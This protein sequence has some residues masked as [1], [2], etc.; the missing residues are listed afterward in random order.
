MQ[1]R[2]ATET[3]DD[4]R[5]HAQHAPE[6]NSPEVS[7]V[8]R[9]LSID[10]VIVAMGIHFLANVVLMVLVIVTAFQSLGTPTYLQVLLTILNPIVWL[11]DPL[12]PDSILGGALCL[13]CFVS[14][15]LLYGAAF[16]WLFPGRKLS[17]E[18]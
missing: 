1:P 11:I 10:R 7:S 18:K 12:L 6:G 3:G 16:A 4:P 15:G 9:T 14:G 2:S 13:L 8:R 5:I 17:V